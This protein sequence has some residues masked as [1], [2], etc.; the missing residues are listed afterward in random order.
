[1][2][3][4]LSNILYFHCLMDGLEKKKNQINRRLCADLIQSQPDFFLS[5]LRQ[6]Y[7][8]KYI[9]IDIITVLINIIII[10][11]TNY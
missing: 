3:N 4:A 8:T 5:E 2:G 9:N 10:V 6:Q 7:V 1:M 11:I